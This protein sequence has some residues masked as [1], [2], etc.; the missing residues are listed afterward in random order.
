MFFFQIFVSL[1]FSQEEVQT[2]LE[3]EAIEMSATLKFTVKEAVEDDDEL[4]YEEGYEDEYE[5][6][7]VDLELKDFVKGVTSIN[8][9]Q[10][11]KA[12]N[13]LK[14]NQVKRRFNLSFPTV[15]DAVGAVVDKLGLAGVEFSDRVEADVDEKWVELAGVHISGSMVLAK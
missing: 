7:A 9:S 5:L 11:K 3:A 13:S 6:N 8:K 15:Q 12:F 4:E 10:F 2:T 14:E 1:E